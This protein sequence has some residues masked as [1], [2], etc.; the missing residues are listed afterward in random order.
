VIKINVCLRADTNPF[1]AAL[2]GRHPVRPA[3]RPTVD[4]RPTEA[5]KAA[6]RYD[7]FTSI[8]L[9]NPQSALAP[10]SGI[11]AATLGVSADCALDAA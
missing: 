4:F 3:V 10:N 1:L 2:Y 7:R 6:I 11:W 9:K 5:S 8:L